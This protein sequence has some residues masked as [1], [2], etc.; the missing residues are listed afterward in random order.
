ML[1]VRPGTVKTLVFRGKLLLKERVDAA[2]D[3]TRRRGR[4]NVG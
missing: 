1:K 4:W 3:M 2:L